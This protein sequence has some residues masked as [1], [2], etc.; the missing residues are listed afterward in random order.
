MDVNIAQLKK[1]LKIGFASVLWGSIVVSQS[2]WT[3]KVL[4]HIQPL[5]SIYTRCHLL[6]ETQTFTNYATRSNLGLSIL[7]KDTLIEP[8][9]E[10]LLP[11][12]QPISSH[13]VFFAMVPQITASF[14]LQQNTKCE[15]SWCNSKKDHEIPAVPA[16]ITHLPQANLVAQVFSFS[17]ERIGHAGCQ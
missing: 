4:L 5:T 8:P 11:E 7:P 12:P 6:W 13:D 3:V 9:I 17:A 2:L 14:T 16:D 10:H 15:L 1:F